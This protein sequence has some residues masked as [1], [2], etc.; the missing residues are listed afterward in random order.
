MRFKKGL[1]LIKD[2][3][4]DL[5][6]CNFQ[7]MLTCQILLDSVEFTTG[8]SSLYYNI[9]I[10]IP[11]KHM[12]TLNSINQSIDPN[13]IIMARHAMFRDFVLHFAANYKVNDAI[14]S[15]RNMEVDTSYSRNGCREQIKRLEALGRV[16]VSQG[17]RTI[18][19]KEFS[20]D[21]LA[22]VKSY[23]PN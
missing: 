22:L 6:S 11:E 4:P 7:S 2:Q 9:L 18:F 23:L 13:F 8:L 19:I 10:N 12:T 20:E 1:E 21:E 14:T 3:L 5:E 17:K 16:R 15:E